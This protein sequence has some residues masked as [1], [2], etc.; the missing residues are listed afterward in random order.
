MLS[1]IASQVEITPGRGKYVVYR[2]LCI[3]CIATPG[4]MRFYKPLERRGKMRSKQIL[5]FLLP[6][7][8]LSVFLTT[9][10]V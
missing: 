2:N 7:D 8:K 9:G 3:G 4:P 5:F 6:A 10:A 1:I